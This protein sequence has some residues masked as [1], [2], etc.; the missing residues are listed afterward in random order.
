M[1]KFSLY[2]LFH[3]IINKIFIKKNFLLDKQNISSH[4]KKV[5]SNLKTPLSGGFVF[6]ILV[7]FFT[8]NMDYV[9]LSFIFVLYLIGIASDTNYI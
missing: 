6:I 7:I 9:V 8:Q 3:F 1:I 5:V 4:K 2:I